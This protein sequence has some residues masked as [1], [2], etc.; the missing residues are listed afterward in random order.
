MKYHL[1][2]TFQLGGED[3]ENGQN[4]EGDGGK[5]AGSGRQQNRRSGSAPRSGQPLQTATITA[6]QVENLEKLI[7]ESAIPKSQVLESYRIKELINLPA[8]RYNNVA[9]WLRS[10]INKKKEAALAN[11]T[12]PAE[13]GDGK[14]NT[15]EAKGA[16]SGTYQQ[17]SSVSL[18]QV[19]KLQALI[20]ETTSD[21]AKFLQKLEVETLAHLPASRFDEAM[22]LLK[23]KKDRMS[24]AALANGTKPAENG[25][26]KGNT[27]EAKGAQS[28]TYQQPP[29][30]SLDQVQKLQA[31]IKE[32]AADE[33]GFLNYLE[34][35]TLA[36][37]PASRFDEAVNALN[38]KKKKSAVNQL[39]ATLTARNI[40]VEVNEE[41]G[42]VQ[43]TPGYQD[44][45]AKAFLKS[46]GFK[47]MI[48]GKIWIKEAA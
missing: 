46:L 25:D 13:N 14:G 11:G 20:K 9:G 39:V 15:E 42:D 4:G 3:A 29:S 22:N 24:K 17:P 1:L 47:Q 40:S 28:G 18:D 44:S 6:E 30:V 37:L 23:D 38:A 48:G 43:A 45:Q 34:V 31:L 36:L 19:Q 2:L 12:K 5:G 21:E 26:G 7:S 8:V 35:E 32:T 41:S 33:V 16:Q 27:E 10:V